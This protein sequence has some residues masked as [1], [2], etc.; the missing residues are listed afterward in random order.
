MPWATRSSTGLTWGK[1]DHRGFGE[2]IVRIRYLAH[3]AAGAAFVA[4][5]GAQDF[6]THGLR[7]GLAALAAGEFKLG[8]HGRMTKYRMRNRS[9][10]R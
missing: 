2:K 3:S 4:A 10:P 7:I 9:K 5:G 8:T 1:L 6:L